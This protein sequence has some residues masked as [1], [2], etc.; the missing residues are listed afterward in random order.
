M[1]LTDTISIGGVLKSLVEARESCSVRGTISLRRLGIYVLQVLDSCFQ[2]SKEIKYL[3]G[4]R[5]PFV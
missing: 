4:L 2:G 1:Q 5:L 3:V